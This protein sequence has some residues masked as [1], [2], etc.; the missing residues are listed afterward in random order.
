M[1]AIEDF[2]RSVKRL[3]SSKSSNWVSGR[4]MRNS[5][6]RAKSFKG[7]MRRDLGLTERRDKVFF[8]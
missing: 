6:G 3:R 7:L 1:K 5:S 2:F 4:K 8:G